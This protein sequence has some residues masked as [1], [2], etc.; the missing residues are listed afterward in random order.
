MLSSSA[1]QANYFLLHVR[2]AG[3][4][5]RLL[6]KI[7]SAHACFSQSVSVLKLM[8]QLAF[9]LMP[10][11]LSNHVSIVRFVPHVAPSKAPR[12]WRQRAHF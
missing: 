12:V 5:T 2:M 11:L 6:D 8:S 1:G 7:N 4:Q 10:D 9:H 3:F